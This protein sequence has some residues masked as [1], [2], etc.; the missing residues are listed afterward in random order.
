[1]FPGMWSPVS[2][3]TNFPFPGLCESGGFR[4]GQILDLGIG[5]SIWLP[6]WRPLGHIEN[7]SGQE[8]LAGVGVGGFGGAGFVVE[9]DVQEGAWSGDVDAVG[10]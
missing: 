7:L 5:E 10:G 3:T 1:M 6:A 2:C 4:S 9:A 8:A